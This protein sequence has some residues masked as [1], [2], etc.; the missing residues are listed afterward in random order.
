MFPFEDAPFALL[1]YLH[2]YWYARSHSL[3][4]PNE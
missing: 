1:D 4:G 2:A 3:I